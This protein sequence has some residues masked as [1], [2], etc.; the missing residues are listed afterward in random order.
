MSFKIK[1]LWAYISIAEDGEEGICAVMLEDKWMPMVMA[2]QERIK[3]MRTIAE[4]MAKESGKTIKFVRF[5]TRTD[6]ETL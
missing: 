5:S 6:L 2:N 3:S 4:K 1:D